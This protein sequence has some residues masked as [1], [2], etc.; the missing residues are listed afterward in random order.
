MA[1]LAVGLEDRPDALV[2]A[3]LV[4]GPFAG[5][6]KRSRLGGGKG[7]PAAANAPSG[8]ESG[9]RHWRGLTRP[10]R[11]LWRIYVTVRGLAGGQSVGIG[12]AIAPGRESAPARS[13]Q[14]GGRV[15]QTSTSVDATA[16]RV[17]FSSRRRRWLAHRG[18]GASWWGV[19]RGNAPC[20]AGGL[21]VERCLK[22]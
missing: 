20:A 9:K 1:A 4:G 7:E 17:K 5:V 10:A 16:V 22:E 21:A 12:D 8:A 2:V 14:K 18:P 6:E 11:D 19:Q 13:G 15:I 3:D